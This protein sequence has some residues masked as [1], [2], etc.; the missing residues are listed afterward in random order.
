[1]GVLLQK[2]TGKHLL[3]SVCSFRSSEHMVCRCSAN[4]THLRSIAWSGILQE[5][6]AKGKQ[7]DVM[8]SNSSNFSAAGAEEGKKCIVNDQ[9]RPFIVL[10][11]LILTVGLPGNLLSAWAFVRCCKAKEKRS[12]GVYLLNL[13]V[14]NLLFLGALPFKVLKDL[15]AAPW[16]LM[17]FHCQ[18]SAV[19]T[20]ISLYA[21]VAF[22][23][24]IIVDRHLQDRHSAHSL[25]LQEPS[26]AWL[27]CTVVWLLLLVIMVPNMALPTKQVQV[28][29]YL[30]CTSLKEELGLSW[31]T[32][33]VFLNTALFLNASAAVLVSSSLALKHLLRS[34]SAAARRTL[35]SVTLMALAY[36]L[37]FVPYHAVRTPYTLAQ[38]Q[39]IRD[40]RTRRQLF[41]GKEATLVL[42]V[43][44]VCL[45]PLLFFHLDPAFRGVIQ[46]LLPCTTHCKAAADMR[47]RTRRNTQEDQEEGGDSSQL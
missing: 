8:M 46:D 7:P 5:D 47:L 27:L 10:Y 2:Q 44:H 1:M 4:P 24:F 41:L 9:M 37:S 15:G 17:V 25:R 35:V 28:Q 6:Q 34:R 30:S 16:S 19:V 43:L 38:T 22:L 39:V 26:F 18:C 40:C 36:V 12:A 42:S 32:L 3:V 23:T 31:H 45:D 21:S 11:I 14:A 33:T 29:R 20:Y 13:L